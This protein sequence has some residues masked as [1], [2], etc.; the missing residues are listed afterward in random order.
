[1][2]ATASDL[3]SSAVIPSSGTS[4]CLKRGFF[5]WFT[6]NAYLKSARWSCT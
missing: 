5:T 3:G 2:E 1:M 4:I 6:H